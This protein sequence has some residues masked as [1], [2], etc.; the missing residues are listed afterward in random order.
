MDPAKDKVKVMVSTAKLGDPFSRNANENTE[1]LL[2]SIRNVAAFSHESS[3]CSW[4]SDGWV[5]RNDLI[6][7]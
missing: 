7:I 6:T 4:S 2:D 5:T 1:P 3:L